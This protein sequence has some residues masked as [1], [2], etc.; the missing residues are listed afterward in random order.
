MDLVDPRIKTYAV[1]H[2]T[3]LDDGLAVVAEATRAEMP[4]PG[5]MSGRVEVRLLQALIAAARATRVLEVGTFTGFGAL[6]MADALGDD[7]RVTTIEGDPRTAEIARRHHAA[8]PRGERVDLL[9]GD[10]RDVL[11]TV[12]GPFD[13]AYVDASKDQYGDYLELVLPLLAAHGVAVFDNVLRRGHVLDD[14]DEVAQFN[15]R[16]QADPRVRNAML[17][18]GDGLLLVWP[19]PRRTRRQANGKRA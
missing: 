10:A 3:P 15:A 4:S 17:T 12:D 14:G 9:T 6:A 5:M 18:V 2:T 16:V 7:G 1:E 11:R 8:D 19:A 13:V